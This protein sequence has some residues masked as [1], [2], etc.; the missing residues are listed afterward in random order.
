MIPGNNLLTQALSVIGSQSVRLYRNTARTKNELGRFVPAF[1]PGEV[2]AV[3]SVQA[4]PLSAY[5]SRGLDYKK[6][7]VMWF[8]PANV[9]G[10][11]RDRSGDQFEWGGRRYSI[12]QETPWFAQDGW[13][14]I[15]GVSIGVATNA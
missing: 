12:E 3:G 1:A 10:V 2:I 8:V 7:Y 5:A 6:S 4:V 14:Q 9:V 11:D 15:L 13:V